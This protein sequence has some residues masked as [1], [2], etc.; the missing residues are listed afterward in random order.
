MG[1]MKGAWC[2]AV[3][4]AVALALW[5]AAV[6]AVPATTGPAIPAP[7]TAASAPVQASGYVGADTCMTCHEDQATKA[8]YTDSPHARA[9][10]PRSPA[11]AYGCESC[12]GPGQAH[13]EGGG[14]QTQIKNPK[15][16][17]SSDVA[18]ICLACHN[19]GEPA[20]WDGSP[21]D[22]K[23]LSCVTCHSVHD[24]KSE[25]SHLQQ[26]GVLQTCGQCH[27]DKL[28][29]LDKSGHMPVREGKM[30]CA[31]CHNPHGS[32]NNVRLLRAGNSVGEACTSCHTEKRGP[33]L[34]EHQPVRENCSTC[35]DPHGSSNDRMLVAKLP[36]LCQR[37]HVHTRH[38]STIYDNAVINTNTRIFNRGCVNCHQ[39]LHGSNSPSGHTFLR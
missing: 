37:C 14:D 33:F 39:N 31:S 28:M 18:E 6:A 32:R 34:W 30:D 20:A 8:S 5:I 1:R 2:P 9:A 4:V 10:D 38:P 22:G 17:R 26:E 12:H 19:R 29:K 27:R 21:H 13:V 15:T 36:F 23:N 25:A 7:Q 11:A 3:S 35:H 16:L 24:A